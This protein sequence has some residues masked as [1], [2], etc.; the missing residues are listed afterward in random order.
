M[1]VYYD[2]DIDYLEVFFETEANYAHDIASSI[3]E[4]RSEKNDKIIGY[5]FERALSDVSTFDAL[6]PQQRIA[7]L[8]IIGRKRLGID[9]EEMAKK[10]GISY[11]TYQR[12]EEG[13]ISKIDDLITISG[14]LK[15]IDFTPI[16]KKA[17]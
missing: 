3:V 5:A 6:T 4:F 13:D 1:K 17:S 16:L 8:S 12:I 15:D 11:R 2:S 7:L 9:Q 14:T 10:L